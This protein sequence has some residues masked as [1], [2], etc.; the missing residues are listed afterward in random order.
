MNKFCIQNDER[1]N[2]FKYSQ[3]RGGCTL[4]VLTTFFLA[5]AH[6]GATTA[7]FY[8]SH[9]VTARTIPVEMAQ[10]LAG[11]WSLTMPDQKSDL[12]GKKKNAKTFSP[13]FG[14]TFS[15]GY[16]PGY[17]PMYLAGGA[18]LSVSMTL[19]RQCFDNPWELSSTC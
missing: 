11:F 12:S 1:C 17:R 10:A 8:N 16:V 4:L 3:P 14:N 13:S 15:P 18:W 5:S 6:R 19:L 9:I 7:V 2:G